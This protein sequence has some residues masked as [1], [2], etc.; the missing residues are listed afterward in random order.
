MPVLGIIWTFGSLLWTMLVVFFW[1]MI[2]WMFIAVFADIFHRNDLHGWGK[3][4]WIFLIF[5]V[6]F[7]GILIYVIARPRDLAQDREE[8]E[9]IQQAQQNLASYSPSEEL[10][11]L[12]DLHKQGVLNDQEYEH[13]KAK[14]MA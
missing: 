5:V 2:I 1:V 10:T 8:A 7:L 14:A 11:K 13:L 12:A 3:A 4:G 9:Q 6:P